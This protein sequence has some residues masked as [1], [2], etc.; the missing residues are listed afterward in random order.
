MAATAPL[1]VTGAVAVDHLP[2]HVY[3]EAARESHVD[4]ALRGMRGVFGFKRV[5][6][7]INEMTSVVVARRRH[8]E[9]DVGS[10]VRLNRGDYKG[11]IGRVV[12][13]FDGGVGGARALVR[14]VPRIVLAE[15]AARE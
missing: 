5:L 11:D 8:G 12:A 10:W 6:V 4:D 14:F 1:L 15:Y 13:M 2:G 9:L 7:P 3:V